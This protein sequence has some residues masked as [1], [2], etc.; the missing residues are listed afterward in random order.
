MLSANLDP[1]SFRFGR[2]LWLPNLASILHL[3]NLLPAIALLAMLVAASTAQAAALSW[4]PTLTGGTAGGG[5][6]WNAT[7]GANWWN[8]GGDQTWNNGDAAF[9][10]TT[11]GTV[12]LSS[13]VS[14]SDL[15]LNTTGYTI[16]GQ[17]L[18]LTSGS[19]TMNASSGTIAS[20]I[21]GTVGLT[22][23]GTGNLHLTTV[24]SVSGG[25]NINSGTLTLNVA[26]GV[27]TGINVSGGTVG[28]NGE[29]DLNLAAS[30]AVLGG[31]NTIAANLLIQGVINKY[32]ASS[33]QEDIGARLITLSGG[34]MTSVQA[35]AGYVNP[36][37]GTAFDAWDMRGGT[38]AT[39]VGTTNYVTGPGNFSIRSSAFLFNLG[40][41]STLN[42]STAVDNAQLLAAS[43][44]GNSFT[45]NQSGL[46]AIVLSA[47]DNAVGSFSING[48]TLTIGGGGSLSSGTVSANSS[49]ATISVASGASFNYSSTANQVLSGVISGAGNLVQSGISNLTLSNSTNS[50]TGLATVSAGTLTLS[51]SSALSQGLFNTNS[52]GTLNF[53]ALTTLA[54]GGLQGTGT[55]TMPGSFTLDL[56][57]ANNTTFSGVLAGSSGSLVKVG[58]GL[59][60]LAGNNT[61]GGA[62]TINNGALA[63]T[64]A[65]P[66]GNITLA[67]GGLTVTPL[68]TVNGWVAKLTAGG[69]GSVELANGE[70]TSEG[71]SLGS[72]TLGLGAAPGGAATYSGT[73]TPT[74]GGVYGLGGGG[75]LTVTSVLSGGANSVVVAQAGGPAVL[76]ANNSAGYGNTSITAG[77]LQ[78]GNGGAAGTLGSGTVSITSP[79]VLTFDRSDN[80]TYSNGIGGT[81][82]VYQVGAGTLNLAG[83]NSLTGTAG[84]Y[85]GTL[86]VTGT[87]SASARLASG[88]GAIAYSP[89]PANQ[90]QT[91]AGFTALPGASTVTNNSSGTLAL[92]ALSQTI[93]GAATFAAT[94]GPITTT[95]LNTNGILGVWAFVGS[96]ANTLYAAN[97]PNVSGGTISGYTLATVES[98]AASAWGGIGSG[99]NGTVNYNITATNPAYGATGL[100]RWVNTLEY[101]GTGA[102]TQAGN[103]NSL[104]LMTNG[105]MNTGGGVFTIGGAVGQFSISSGST[106][107]RELV[108]GPMTNNIVLNVAVA[109]NGGGAA[110]LTKVG[111]FS[112]QLPATNTYTGATTIDAGTLNPTG[113]GAINSTSAVNIIGGNFQQDSSVAATPTVNLNWGTLSGTG[114]ITGPVVV[115]NSPAAVVQPGDSSAGTLSLNSL[116]FNGAGQISVALGSSL[117]STTSLSTSLAGQVVVNYLGVQI[118]TAGDFELASYLGSLG[119]AGSSGFTLASNPRITANLDFSTAGQINV[120]ITSVD[121]PV[122]SG[123]ASSVWSTTPVGSPFNWNLAVA[124]TGTEFL[125][126]DYVEFRDGAK[127]GIV[128][129]SNG[130]VQPASVTFNNSALA[131][132]LSG[133]NGIANSTLGATSLIVNGPGLVT[134]A[135]T[136][137]YTGATNVNGGTLNLTGAIANTAIAVAAGGTFLQG[138]AGLINGSASLSTSGAATLAGINTYTG[139]TIVTGTGALTISGTLSTG[140]AGQITVG[141]SVIDTAVLN[142]SGLLNANFTTAPSLQ[143]GAASGGTGTI[144]MTGGTLNTAS[145]LW[146]SSAAGAVGVMNMSGGVA[147]IGS[148]LAVGRGGNGGFLNVSG[149]SLNVATNDLT[150]ASFTGNQ[151]TVTVSGGTVSAVNSIFVGEAGTGLLTI[152]GT[153]LVINNSPL[154]VGE[155]S[156]A[157]GTLELDGG[158][159]NVPSITSGI[160]GVTSTLNMNG[161]TIVAAT[162]ST[163]FINNIGQINVRNNNSTLNNN[164]FNLTLIDPLVHSAIGGDNAIDG[165]MTFTGSGVTT[166]ASNNSYTGPTNINRG[167][168]VFPNFSN[169]GSMAINGAGATLSLVD[170]M[171]NTLNLAGGL[172]LAGSSAINLEIES[173]QNDLVAAT[174]AASLSGTS[175]VNLTAIGAISSGSYGLITASG[176]LNASNFAVGS[177]P[178]GFFQYSLSAPGGTELVLT[179]SGNATPSAAY[180][181]GSA[182]R[183]GGNA[184][185]NWN[186]GSTS[187]NWSLDS[188]GSTDAL[189]IPGVTTQVYFTASS[190]VSTS[191]ALTT[192]LDNNYSIQGLTV[193]VPTVSGT[194]ITSNIINLNGKTLTTGASGLTLDFTSL[195]SAT[196][197]GGTIALN[198]SQ[199]WA[200]NNRSLGLTVNAPISAVSGATTLSVNGFGSGGVVLGGALSNGGGTLGLTLSQAGTTQLTGNL[201][202]TGN[203]VINSGTVVLSGTNTLTNIQTSGAS[204]LTIAGM[205]TITSGNGGATN[206]LGIGNNFGDA[207]VLNVVPGATLIATNTA[208]WNI[209]LGVQSGAYG[210][211]NVS[212][213][214]VNVW[215][216]EVGNNGYGLYK[217]TGG[218][219]NVGQW[220]LL[221]RNGAGGASPY[222]VADIS[223]GQL[224]VLA[225]ELVDNWVGLGSSVNVRGSG[226]LN[227]T[228]A[229]LLVG[230]SG[231]GGVLNLLTG[232]TLEASAVRYNNGIGSFNLNGGVLS[233]TA[234]STNFINSASFGSY[235][236]SGGANINT[237]FNITIAVPLL[238]PS[239][240]GVSNIA[241]QGT[242]YTSPP[243]VY[244]S[245]SSGTVAA[246]ATGVATIDGSGNLTGI[247][248]TN[249]GVNYTSP[250]LTLYGGGGTLLS[251][252]ISLAANTSGGLTKSGS[253][254]L[255]LSASNTY[256]GATQITGGTL[257]LNGTGT[258]NSSSGVAVNGGAFVQNST[259]A[260]APA[261]MLTS[262]TVGG[263]GTID[264]LK[265]ASNSAN[266]IQSSLIS[267]ALTVASL[268]FQGS[269]DLALTLNP[270]G[271]G[272]VLGTTSLGASGAAG[273]VGISLSS[274][275]PLGAGTYD[276]VSYA[277]NIGGTGSSAFTLL[278]SPSFNGHVT[279]F[280]LVDLP[281]ELALSV[282]G[283]T[284]V[285]TGLDGTSGT[286]AWHVGSTGANH[287]WQISGG[288]ATDFLAGDVVRFD[289]TNTSGNN[290]ISVSGGIAA[291]SITFSNSVNNYVVNSADGTGITSGSLLK[292]GIGSLTLN[293]ADSYSGGTQITGG[294]LTLG[295]AAA[296]GAATGSLTANGGTL[297]LQGNTLQI[298][299]FSGAAGVV[300]SST[301]GSVTLA[302]A[303]VAGSS[304]TFNGTLQNG[305]GT[306]NLTMNGGGVQVLTGNNTFLGSVSVTSGTLVLAGSN[307][308]AGGTNIGTGGGPGTVRATATGALGTGTITFD[309]FGNGSTALLQLANNAT[310]N[311]PISMPGR[312][313]G[314]YPIENLSGSNTLS[315]GITLQ[316]GGTY[317]I[318]SDSGLLT[319]AGSTS[320]F[321]NAGG[322]R[323]VNLE[324]NGN[325]LISG[326]VVNGNATGGL[327]LTKLGSGTWSLSGNNTYTGST[328]VFNGELVLDSPGA[329]ASG[330]SLIVGANASNVTLALPLAEQPEI[331]LPA[332]VSAGQSPGVVPASGPATVPEPGTLLLLGVAG[333]AAWVLRRRKRGAKS[334]AGPPETSRI[335][336]T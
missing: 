287:N 118:P 67:G 294:L 136:N 29:L 264:S 317:F 235:V 183:S 284:L 213:G 68:L 143:A 48:G 225:N 121:H 93:G 331:G 252:T 334:T 191:S 6:T 242:G 115:A 18:S 283:A 61:Y 142:T 269:G 122:W 290:T 193:I 25:Y 100:L 75:Q 165:G 112:L 246:F 47:S 303:P 167:T 241:V 32:F 138:A 200:N 281:G 262:G 65:V 16:T 272:P 248:I 182:S 229:S 201:T 71:V 222:G 76:L 289:D 224:N 45:F 20:I 63:F 114:S 134:L 276:L 137:S 285:W 330:N 157:V 221:S 310:L 223:G 128:Q 23:A 162:G 197:S 293:T 227:T 277:G 31:N 130:N 170:G 308:Y 131:Y 258:I 206:V 104:L 202:Y 216:I 77:T 199:S 51:N 300:T 108:V 282:S 107:A 270:G 251:S 181:T 96:G 299:S 85:Y 72:P 291:T 7:T 218:T 88:G 187:S 168:V 105:I 278:S 275:A 56:G 84:A 240:S 150:I 267:G 103:N 58:A 230:G 238:A 164:G 304:S 233:P 156:G 40:A 298:G 69:T 95:T 208:G 172:S 271:A 261:V 110:A 257:Q 14:A 247:T 4:D 319:I 268:G 180:W 146:L 28:P 152:S 312:T 74:S 129:I 154:F 309:S 10:G 44:A 253:A 323:N 322:T 43:Q 113:A 97:G 1:R 59:I 101:S 316:T 30:S 111:P 198:G 116:S 328:N 52:T 325:G 133:A 119:G 260:E 38:L 37:G 245:D 57:N 195:A 190:V 184:A 123:S 220:F 297:D 255:A 279:G 42:F 9:G 5:G 286:G 175:T 54:L 301:S 98:N 205:T 327:A 55:F 15:F 274:A 82:A 124:G 177:R 207:G 49:S 311:N 336:Q 295:N 194:Q 173:G 8:G 27:A 305:G 90:S 149:G 89:S 109:N 33:T 204:V 192:T 53:G 333:A 102:S 161:G 125:T 64:S 237:N 139:N 265:V 306:L 273:S 335:C 209:G 22:E 147:N 263:T 219:V 171:I 140:A 92:G 211:M 188:A 169:I 239:G 232:G 254:T 214:S 266:T 126:N 26:A 19:I 24:S 41:G 166:L 155:A 332:L 256:A 34:T 13:P 127:T 12:T 36:Y 329:I 196:L 17:T 292:A 66:S 302:V 210:A 120:N 234:S 160:S 83:N 313:N 21:T 86:N 320:I 148:W 106:G 318:Q 91:V 236:Y 259:I 60:T 81:G 87:L 144:N 3:R 203:T 2:N 145:E 46:G 80:S 314:A 174:G 307:A 73:M 79:G 326:A 132:T 176:G 178:G 135:T 280:S 11:G 324:G 62:T 50:F 153:G 231:I 250:V 159:L 228:T 163:T 244:L 186:F 99:G 315:G 288:S 78:V 212:G 243:L 39:A 215:E 117:L 249:P 185:N 189:Q 217:Q 70:N 321:S 296:L 226:L 179:V 141:P 94:S 158:T 35:T 151:G